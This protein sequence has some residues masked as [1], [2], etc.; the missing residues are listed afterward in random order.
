M[1]YC[2]NREITEVSEAVNLPASLIL[3]LDVRRLRPSTRLSDSVS[4]A[5]MKLR[6]ELL[7]RSGR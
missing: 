6:P 2:I 1:E 7:A 3:T 4:P 5:R